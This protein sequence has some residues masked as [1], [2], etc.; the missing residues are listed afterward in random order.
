MSID[1]K[2]LTYFGTSIIL[3]IWSWLT[4]SNV[5]L[6]MKLI[7]AIFAIIT[8]VAAYRYYTSGKRKNQ[9]EIKKILKDLE[10]AK[11]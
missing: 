6:G 2:G 8:S 7:A 11:K 10:D 3:N 9:L 1:L 5:D 4:P